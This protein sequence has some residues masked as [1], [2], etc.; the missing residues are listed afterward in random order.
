MNLLIV[1][2]G[3]CLLIAPGLADRLGCSLHPAEWSRL[4]SSSLRLGLWAVRI[5]L[6]LTAAPALLRAVGGQGAVE[7]CHRLIG[8]AVPGGDITGFA[9]AGV[10][11]IAEVR[12]HLARRAAQNCRRRARVES[13]LG[14][15]SPRGNE[16]L[17]VLPT[18]DL[19]AYAVD[20][21]PAQIV[22][23]SR[24]VST[25]SGAELAA[26]IG[27]EQCHMRY[28]HDRTLTLVGSVDA[29]LGWLPGVRRSSAALRLALERWADECAAEPGGNRHAVEAALRKAVLSRLEALPA[30]AGAEHVAE[31]LDALERDP[32]SPGAD[33]R[34]LAAAPTLALAMS[35]TTALLLLA[36]HAPHELL[37]VVGY[38]PL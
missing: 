26:V 15:H 19:V 4:V 38:C 10:I 23:S 6:A 14:E 37:G 20:G 13:W 9:S 28:G 21:R 22:V 24:L 18:D 30:F 34:L 32:P 12:L 36:L 1:A 31:R 25:L 2:L 29:T 16:E 7:A 8:I 11:V 5:G 27:H 33:V 17:V 3:L 35:L